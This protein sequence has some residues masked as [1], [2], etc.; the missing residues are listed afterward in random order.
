M[1]QAYVFTWGGPHRP[2][3]PSLHFGAASH[4]LLAKQASEQPWPT[5]NFIGRNHCQDLMLCETESQYTGP[6][7]K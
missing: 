3:D 4:T 1:V 5:R 6:F 7:P 2:T